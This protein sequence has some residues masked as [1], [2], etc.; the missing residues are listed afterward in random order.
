MSSGRS[1]RRGQGAAKHLGGR[2]VRHRLSHKARALAVRITLWAAAAL[3]L[4][5]AVFAAAMFVA[6][7]SLMPALGNAVADAVS[8][9]QYKNPKE[10]VYDR[11]RYERESDLVKKDVSRVYLYRLTAGVLTGG[12]VVTELGTSIPPE[13]DSATGA[14]DADSVSDSSKASESDDQALSPSLADF[15]P[16]S[17]PESSEL[18]FSGYPWLSSSTKELVCEVV[19][20]ARLR[21]ADLGSD[22]VYDA[23]W[24]VLSQRNMPDSTLNVL[25]EEARMILGSDFSQMQLFVEKS[26]DG[27]LS[28]AVYGDGHAMV[29]DYTA[30]NQIKKMKVPVAV[31]LYV[32]GCVAVM[33]FAVRRALRYFDALLDAVSDVLADAESPVDLPAELHFAQNAINAVKFE[34]AANARAAKAAE[35]RKNELVAYLAHDIKTPLTSIIGYL[36]L[37][38]EAPDMPLEQRA[39]YAGIASEKAARLEGLIDE[40]FEISRYNLQ[41]IPIERVRVDAALFCSQVAEEFYPAAEARGIEIVVDAPADGETVFIDARKLAR[42]CGNVLKNAVAYADSGTQIGFSADIVAA[43]ASEAKRDA[44]QGASSASNPGAE[45]SSGTLRIVIE[46]QGREISPEHLQRIFERFYREDSA[47]ATDGGGAGLGLAIAREIVQ[48]HGGTIEA[49][50]ENGITRFEIAIPLS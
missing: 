3:L 42:A 25:C 16:A 15:D 31:V 24:T 29:R 50:S 6:D 30:Y 18:D 39:R 7:Y 34:N 38:E 4:Y 37:L 5:S 48:A 8:P 9:W 20:L 11:D 1:G 14:S 45:R 49:T 17:W 33:A 32:A 10:A 21:A 26:W 2:S 12:A 44:V 40:F 22:A 23:V 46:N 13:S 43:S 28:V 27:T 47:R 35:Q 36:S 19:D 41:R